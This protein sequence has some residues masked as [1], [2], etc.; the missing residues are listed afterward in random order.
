MGWE[1]GGGRG[2][3]R[4]APHTSQKKLNSAFWLTRARVAEVVV[5]A[6]LLATGVEVEVELVLRLVLVL[7]VLVLML[8]VVLVLVLTDCED[9]A[10]AAA[11][12]FALH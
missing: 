11:L 12:M 2:A 4:R 10:A 7:V 9:C 6:T 3:L 5:L 8:L 1:G